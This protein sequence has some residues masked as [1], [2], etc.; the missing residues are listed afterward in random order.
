MGKSVT[1]ADFQREME[2]ASGA[3]LSD[4][5]REWVYSAGGGV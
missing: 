3:D 5:F 2:R 4:F 1:T